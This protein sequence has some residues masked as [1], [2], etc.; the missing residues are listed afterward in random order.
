[1]VLGEEAV[2]YV[3][4]LIH[5]DRDDFYVGQLFL[6]GEEAG[7]LF[8]AGRAPGGPQ[9]EDNDAS[10]QLAEVDGSAAIAQDKLLCGLVDVAGMASPVAAGC[11]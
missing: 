5:A 7:Q 4:V 11:Q 9:V 6:Q 8:D 1:V 3:G 10:A 2:V